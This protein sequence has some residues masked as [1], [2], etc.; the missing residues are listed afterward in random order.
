[1]MEAAAQGEG[2]VI[3]YTNVGHALVH[4]SE[5]T[6]GALLL[7]MQ[8]DLGATE[9]FMGAVASVFGWAF[10]ATALP[11]GFLADRWGPA[12]VLAFTFAS[13][14]GACLL[15]AM[16][17]SPW[18]LALGMA[19]LGLAT[20]FYH[21]AGTT[22]IAQGVRSR[23]LAMGYHGVAGN[24][25]MGLAPAIAGGIATL[26][27][28]RGAYV[29]LA[30][31]AA[32]LA[33]WASRLRVRPLAMWQEGRHQA[34]F[35]APVGRLMVALL[36]VYVGSILMGMVYRGSMT[37]LPAHLHEKASA[38]F[39]D[40]LTTLVLLIGAVRG[41]GPHPEGAPGVAGVLG[42]GLGPAPTCPGGTA[43][44]RA[45]GS[46][47]G[48]L[49]IPALRSSAHLQHPHSRLLAA[50]PSGQE[51]RP[52]LSRCLWPRRRR[53]DHR[54]GNGGPVGHG[55]RLHRHGRRMG[56]G[57]LGHGAPPVLGKAADP[58]PETGPYRAR[59]R[60]MH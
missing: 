37:F 35:G 39:A 54:R 59:Q 21:P 34:G 41:R 25:G 17:A 60:I 6:Y 13:A 33:L 38:R 47:G 53:R 56:P 55:G 15:V 4:A 22:L 29:A 30:A 43:G 26:W 11:A 16:A 8:A 24:V 19:L 27:T 5:V 44:G 32:A 2:R 57:P 10:G 28:W 49:Y 14:C 12:K 1:M 42:G 45:D 18:M 40:S 23:G 36:A 50:G 9:A 20:G 7:R 3:A 48:G 46:G 51:L 52:G 58:G 31:S